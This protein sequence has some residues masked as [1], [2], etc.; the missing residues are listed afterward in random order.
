DCFAIF[1]P[2]ARWDLRAEDDFLAIIVHERSVVEIAA[3]TRLAN[4]PARKAAR[5]FRHILLCVAAIHAECV[6]FHNFAAIV[7]V[8]AARRTLG[9]GIGSRIL[10]V[11]RILLPI[12]GLLLLLPHLLC[13]LAENGG[14]AFTQIAELPLLAHAAQIVRG[15]DLWQLRIR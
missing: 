13:L 5:H 14:L 15:S 1:H 7:F 4:R 11:L 9:I 8:Q 2:A 6:Q 3:L 10:R 12:S